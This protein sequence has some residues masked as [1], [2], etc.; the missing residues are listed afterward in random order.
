MAVLL[1]LA[2]S[3]LFVYLGF[4]RV[5]AN[6]LVAEIARA[7]VSLLS[8]VVVLKVL[9][10]FLASVRTVL[11][12]RPIGAYPLGVAFRSVLLAFTAN[13]LFP[14]RTGELFRI[15]Y[16]ARHGSASRS[17]CLAVVLL[18]RLLDSFV[19]LSIFLGALPAAALGFAAGRPL[20]YLGLSFVSAIAAATWISRRPAIFVA[21]IRRIFSLVGERLSATMARQAGTFAEGLAGLH[22][23]PRVVGAVAATIAFWIS[24]LVSIRI[25]FWAFDLA[26][27][28]YAPVLV[29]GFAAFGSAL[30]ASPG[31]IGTYHYFVILALTTLNVDPVVARSTAIVGHAVSFVPLTLAGIP[32]LVRYLMRLPQHPR[33]TSDGAA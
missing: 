11:L 5:D 25:W 30:P 22:S 31:Q 17:S 23:M 9:A 4:R 14:L 1:G 20:I 13:N 24:S 12:L 28:W 10:F 29:L 26:L 33:A 8:L 21:L 3:A 19:L 18:E 7:S 15:D 2:L 27:P 16:L 6:A 32:L